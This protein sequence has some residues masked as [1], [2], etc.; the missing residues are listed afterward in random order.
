LEHTEADHDDFAL[1]RRADQEIHELALRIS[2][3]QKETNER[4]AR[5][6]VL[7][8]LELSIHGLQAGDLYSPTR[9]LVQYD[10]VTMH[11]G[12]WTRKDRC[13]FLFDDLLIIT[14]VGKRAAR[15]VRRGA[16]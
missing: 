1:L 4:D 16:A 15:D 3:I 13:L 2:A 12:P 8:Q 14:S 5:Q 6:K 10:L 11:N 7:R 9:N